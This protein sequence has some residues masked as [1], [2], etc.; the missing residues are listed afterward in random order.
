MGD[1]NQDGFINIVDVVIM[2]TYVLDNSTLSDDQMII[3][4]LNDDNII[5]VVDIITL[6]NIILGDI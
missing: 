1:T 4:D 6:L 5:N 3:A 2:I